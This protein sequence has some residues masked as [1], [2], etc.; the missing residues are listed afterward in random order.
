VGGFFAQDFEAAF[1]FIVVFGSEGV[2]LE[3]KV[4]DEI[5]FMRIGYVVQFECFL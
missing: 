4:S 5:F 3:W 1:F 2:V